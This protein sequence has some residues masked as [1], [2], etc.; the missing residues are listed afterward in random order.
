MQMYKAD[1]QIAYFGQKMVLGRHVSRQ[2]SIFARMQEG[3][4]WPAGEMDPN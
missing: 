4:I 1:V 2:L 3:H